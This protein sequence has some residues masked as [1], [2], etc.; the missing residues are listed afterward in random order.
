MNFV[1][2]TLLDRLTEGSAALLSGRNRQEVLD[3]ILLIVRDSGFDRVRLYLLSDEGRSLKGEAQ[4]GM[5]RSNFIGVEWPVAQDH[6]FRK[7]LE[8]PRP[9]V[10]TFEAGRPEHSEEG[11]DKEDVEEWAGVPLRSGDKVIGHLSADNKYSRRKILEEELRPL[12]LFAAQAAAAIE[13]ADL[14]ERA[15]QRARQLEALRLTTLAITSTE[16]SERRT[17]LRTIIEHAAGLL[18]AKSGGIYEHHPERGELELIADHNRPDFVGKVLK[19]GD[20]MA[21]RL[22]QSGE[23]YRIV[24]DYNTHPDR[25]DIYGGRRLF[26]AVLEVPLRWRARILGVLY[27]DDD[28]GRKFT[29]EDARLLGLFADQSAIVIVN[30]ELITRDAHLVGELA[31]ERERKDLVS[32][33]LPHA[34]IAIDLQGRVTEF[35]E[36]AER[37]MGYSSDEMIGRPVYD[38]YHDD[39]EPRLIGNLLHQSEDGRLVNHVTALRDKFGQPVSIRLTASWLYDE[40]G[41]R[42][43]SVGHIRQL[44]KYRRQV[45]LLLNA[46]NIVVQAQDLASGLQK[47][48]E[49]LATLFPNTFCRILLFDESDSQMTV[50]AACY[51]SRGAVGLKFATD[52]GRQSSVSYYEGLDQILQTGKP[53]TLRHSDPRFRESLDRLGVTLDL[54]E[55]IQSLMI[56][57]LKIGNRTLGLLDLGEFCLE[58]QSRFTRE[59]E[60]L[61][62][63]ISEQTSVLIDRMLTIKHAE[64]GRDR[65]LS[66]YRVRDELNAQEDPERL[67]HG[68]VSETCTAASAS[69]VHVILID[70][71]ERVRIWLSIPPKDSSDTLIIRPN[72]ISMNVFRTGRAEIIN[73]TCKEAARLHP[74]LIKKAGAAVCVPMSLPH[75]RIGVMWIHYPQP[76]G[77]A[78]SEIM[79]LHF[80]ANQAAIAYENAQEV[81]RLER[82]RK[83]VEAVADVIVSGA[84]Q[85]TL[86]TIAVEAR[87]TIQ[88]DVVVLFEYDQSKRR[89]MF[90]TIRGELQSEKLPG[91]EE[92]WNYPMVHSLLVEGKLRVVENV[93]V[94]PNFRDSKFAKAEGIESCIAVPLRASGDKVGM[95]FIN[96]R[97]RRRFTED[98]IQTIRFFANQA[99]VAIHYQ[100]Y[101]EQRAKQYEELYRMSKHLHA[102]HNASKAITAGFGHEKEVLDRIVKEAVKGVTGVSGAKAILGMINIYDEGR[103]ELTCRNIYPPAAA[104]GLLRRVGTRW[105]LDRG[106][107]GVAGRAV[108]SKTSQLVVNV[109]DDP[110]Y[111]EIN[112]STRSELSVPLKYE[113]RILGVINVES[114]K[115][116]GF[117]KEDQVALESLADIAAI[118]VE[119]ARQYEEL[120]RTHEKLIETRARVEASTTLAWLGMTNN[121]W[122]HIIAGQ[123]AEIRNRTTLIREIMKNGDSPRERIAEH[124][125]LIELL[126]KSILEKPIT[127]PLTSEQGM[128]IFNI[129]DLVIERL[130]QLRQKEKY[131]AVRLKSRPAAR[132]NLHVE[133]SFEWLRRALDILL[134]NAV[135]AVRG[136]PPERRLIEVATD[137][138][139]GQVEI[140]VRD[141]GNG[142]PEPIKHQIFKK[143]IEH[144]DGMGMGLLIAQAIV[145]TYGGRI[146]LS[147]KPKFQGAE[148]IIRLPYKP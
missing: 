135:N 81:E 25:S 99:S 41:Q 101:A 137:L 50:E 7:L 97:R 32:N 105:P 112:E 69:R 33:A 146:Y 134:D 56:A 83:A 26:G 64:R 98:E 54:E 102:V 106:R 22:V 115:I 126:T 29:P 12:A 5:N 120:K 129:N 133:A 86:E 85:D 147:E 17:L 94:E 108:R 80:Y 73:D 121:A 51:S 100:Q 45:E 48:A 16:A 117:D 3:R 72:G 39:Q 9:R 66:F 6:H 92:E 13:K 20:G 24:D 49:M 103:N 18:S 28:V 110:D 141:C 132:R 47:L 128:T 65:L 138:K 122:R 38:L 145:E 77:I 21:G 111:I 114:D 75:K 44:L 116:E 30:Q 93:S 67:L 78:E 82:L 113:G 35:N 61:I 8:D 91:P 36:Q 76:R 4:S 70:E 136:L 40:A 140:A 71:Y 88:C 119:N 14:I 125:Q 109:M 144:G 107:V 37:I 124:L 57:P 23:D 42:V 1:D 89:L 139:D 95:M 127:P 59:N 142:I 27:V 53:V 130:N 90:P 96:Y 79:A 60:N 87:Q 11:L 34:V 63:A 84:R 131:G 2:A 52:S 55:I 68:I 123:A 58:S 74:Q 118:A 46:S 143:R 43:G 62:A 10:F 148:I 31:A 19:I 104:D 15:E